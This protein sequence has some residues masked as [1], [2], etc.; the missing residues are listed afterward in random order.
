MLYSGEIPLKD[1]GLKIRTDGV[2]FL[3]DVVNYP[4]VCGEGARPGAPQ[5]KSV[6]DDIKNASSMAVLYNNIVIEEADARRQLFKDLR[7]YGLT[8]FKT[9]LSL[10]MMDFRS[11][12]YI[13]LY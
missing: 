11:M 9:E 4:I 6:D 10:T 2:G 13:N 3:N 8:A 12:H 5:K 1:L 7:V